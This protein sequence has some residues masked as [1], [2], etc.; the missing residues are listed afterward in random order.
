MLNLVLLR[1][2]SSLIA[3]YTSFNNNN[4]NKSNNRNNNN[5]NIVVYCIQTP[6][7]NISI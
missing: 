3:C 2:Y 1:T 7:E 6:L 5:N 4:N